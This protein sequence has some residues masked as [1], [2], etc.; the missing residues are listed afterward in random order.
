M[1]RRHEA[2][3]LSDAIRTEVYLSPSGNKQKVFIFNCK[4][5][6]SEFGKTAYYAKN[7][8]GFCKACA[9]KHTHTKAPD[10]RESK[11]CN[12]CH[13]V[14]PMNDFRLKGNHR[15]NTCIHC[16][17]IKSTFGINANDYDKML[18]KQNGVCGICKK[19]EKERHQNGKLR[20]LAIDHCHSTG[21]IRGLLCT[22]CNQGLGNFKDNE[23]YLEQAIKYLKENK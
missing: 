10:T 22:K 12:V 1:K 6:G 14:R 18:K 13:K 3:D 20:K 5:C 17:N 7:C 9:P 15:K 19:E 4:D 2:F 23:S 21:K 11:E 8:T 16:E